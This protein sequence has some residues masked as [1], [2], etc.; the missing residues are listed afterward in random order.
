V[1]KL[2]ADN[3]LVVL[4][5]FVLVIQIF[6]VYAYRKKVKYLNN[7]KETLY[8]LNEKVIEAKHKDEVYEAILKA[9]IEMVPKATKGSI[10]IEGE[11][12]LFHFAALYGYPQKVKDITLVKE[13]TFL[14]VKNKFAD[15]AIIQNPAKFNKN[16]L[17]FDKH[18][19]FKD[20]EA[21]DI[22]CTLSCPITVNDKVVGMIN[23]D[24]TR[25]NVSFS[26]EDV[27]YMKYIIN[28]LKLVLR[29]FLIQD[30]LRFKA[31]FDAL[32]GLY[33]RGYLQYLIN[34]NLEFLKESKNKSSFIFID[35]DNFKKI[36][37]TY[38]HNVGDKVLIIIANILKNKL[39]SSNVYGRMAGDEFIILLPNT[40]KEKAI[41]IIEEI[42]TAYRE[43]RIFDIKLDFS[44]G[45]VELDGKVHCFDDLVNNADLKMYERKKC[46]KCL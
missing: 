30:D 11:D 24:T 36:N 23:L 25:R 29:T 13:E 42:R 44:Y 12:G 38:G 22:Y 33:N 21:L 43:E 4:C 35:L 31:N 27:K 34:Y 6:F 26:E 3:L 2:L 16:I 14:Y 15:I 39:S 8:G 45:I 7:T 19:I 32:T 10:L 1:L 18:K 40:K 46:K 17:H 9:A 28:E 41:K 5:F 37:D 20:T